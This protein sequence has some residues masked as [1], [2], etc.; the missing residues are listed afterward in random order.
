MTTFSA[1]E[2]TA[3]I[4]DVTT[5]MQTLEA[6]S[7]EDAELVPLASAIKLLC[8]Y[9]AKID[10]EIR[11]RVLVNNRLVPGVMLKDEVKHRV[12]N[13]VEAASSLA[14]EQFGDAAFDIK[15]KSPAGIEKL[16]PAGKAFAAMGSEKP[17]AGKTIAY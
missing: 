16:G 17:A 6:S 7:I 13:D 4:A 11:T 3:L 8:E 9:R 12:W 14:R 2:L 1:T 5:E 10:A 15:L